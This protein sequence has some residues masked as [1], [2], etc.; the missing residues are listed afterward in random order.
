MRKAFVSLKMNDPYSLT[1]H[2]HVPRTQ[3][4]GRD[5]HAVPGVMLSL[6]AD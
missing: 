6:P 2:G 1:E 3:A 5:S 4:L